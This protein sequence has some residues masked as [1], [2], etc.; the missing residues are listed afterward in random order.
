MDNVSKVKGV[1]QHYLCQRCGH[2][3]VELFTEESWEK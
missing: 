1:I 2:V 3:V